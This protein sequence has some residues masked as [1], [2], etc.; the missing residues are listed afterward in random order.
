MILLQAGHPIVESVLERELQANRQSGGLLDMRF[1]DFDHSSWTL[2]STES[3]YSVSL[4]L[5][6]SCQSDLFSSSGAMEHMN[7]MYPSPKYSIQASGV[8]GDVSG[9]TITL[10]WEKASMKSMDEVKQIALL[11]RN[12]L[13]VPILQALTSYDQWLVED[14]KQQQTRKSQLYR[15]CYRDQEAFY[16]QAYQDRVIVIFSA[17]FQDPTDAVVGKIFLQEFVDAR[18][19]NALQNAPQ[20]IYSKDPPP[21]LTSDAQFIIQTGSSGGYISFILFPRHIQPSKRDNAIS[22]LVG[23]RSYFHYHIKCSKAYLHSRLRAKMVEFSKVLNRARPETVKS[24][25]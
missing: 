7:K 24:L 17:T 4:T 13:A 3:S 19:S 12:L 10:Q 20:V 25:K 14:P 2:K 11:K 22:M 23:F 1:A 18:K 6:G 8:V 16:V 5:T 9:P 21:E 15:L